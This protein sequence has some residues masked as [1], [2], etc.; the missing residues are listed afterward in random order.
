LPP[1]ASLPARKFLMFSENKCLVI[2]E[3]A[4]SH[5][6]S[7]GQAHA[8]IDAAARAGADVIK[9][10]THIAAEESTLAEPW[11]VRF[12]RQD[13]T[14]LDYWRR[15]E[16]TESQWAG[17]KQ[18]ADEAKIRF[19]SSPFSLRAVE[20]LGRIGL[21]AWKVASGE[22]TNYQLLDAML[23]TRLPILLSTGM[24][25]WAEIDAAVARV[26]A[27]GNDLTVMQC[28][29]EY[30]CPPARTGL[31]VLE[32]LRTR[33]GCRV[34]ISDHSG[35]IYCGIASAALGAKVIEVHVAFSREMFG[36]DVP[37]SITFDELRQLTEGV[38][39][40]EE[41]LANPVD[42]DA[43]AEEKANLRSIFGRSIVAARDL[44]AGLE[45]TLEHLALKKPGTGLPESQLGALLGRRL[46]NPLPRDQQLKL[47]D[48][49]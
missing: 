48:I 40:V 4:Q 8:F 37:A 28:T 38:R 14:R 29:S 49:E 33:Y 19:L 24:S 26:R 9:F 23:A 42:K 10:Q 6:G 30:P 41:A 45:L 47:D 36:P 1:P 12:S 43:I 2:A 22:I 27:S 34:G 25:S 5:D 15:M 21:P 35:K 7:L 32:M 39:F 20:M 31:G 46:R 3:V 17:L 13:A 16:F 18:H 44:A 11:R